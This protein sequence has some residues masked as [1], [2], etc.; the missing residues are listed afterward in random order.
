MK[1]LADSASEQDLSVLFS[2]HGKVI[3]VKVER[4]SDGKSRGM[5]YVQLQSKEQA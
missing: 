3:S 2:K 1:N 4:Y 5:A